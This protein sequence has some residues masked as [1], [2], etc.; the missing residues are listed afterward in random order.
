MHLIRERL[1]LDERDVS[2]SM[3]R[4]QGAGG[5]NVNK[6]SCAIHLRFDVLASSLPP[7]AKAMVLHHDDQR[8]SKDG[9]IVI[10]AQRFRS[11][12][13]NRADALER[14]IALIRDATQQEAPRKA[15][16]P[17]RRARQQRMADKT[18]RSQIKLGRGKNFE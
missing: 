13:L 16:R 18:R 17:S 14:L 3:I 8:I 15:T 9:V 1:W 12:E 7:E 10:K 2:F 11:L 6:V 4:A 5:Q